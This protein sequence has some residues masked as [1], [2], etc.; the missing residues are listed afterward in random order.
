MSDNVYQ[1]SRA[2]RTVWWPVKINVPQDGG[3]VNTVTIQMQLSIP[4]KDEARE[5]SQLPQDEFEAYMLDRVLD[6]K[7]VVDGK[8]KPIPFSKEMLADLLQDQYFES[9]L[10]VALV[11]AA[12][13]AR[14]KN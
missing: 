4:K 9:G 6:W 14:E 8:K 2:N 5:A 12:M 3:G 11:K 10:T 7:G 1:F 13:G